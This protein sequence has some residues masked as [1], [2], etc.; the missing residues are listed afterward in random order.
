VTARPENGPHGVLVG[1]GGASGLLAA[2]AARWGGASVVLLEKNPRVGKKLLTTGNHQCNLS[3]LHLSADRFHGDP[4]LAMAVIGKFDLDA[5]L[6]FFGR[7]GLQSARDGQGRVYP[8]SY[9][10]ASVLDALRLEAEES[11]V[12][13]VAGTDVAEIERQGKGLAVTAKGGTRFIARRVILCTGGKAAPHTGSVGGGL[14]LARRLGHAVVEPFPAL[15]PLKLEGAHPRAMQG[16]RWEVVARL[17]VDGREGGTARGEAL[18]A[19]YGLSGPAALALSRNAVEAWSAGRRVEVALDLLPEQ[20]ETETLHCIRSRCLNKPDRSME[21]FLAGW[22]NKRIGQ[23]LLK[24]LGFDWSRPWG[25]LTGEEQ[26]RLA[27]ALHAWTF[28]VAGHTGWPNAQVTAGGVETAEVD[29][30][31]L[32]SRLVP[33]LHFAGEILNVDGD[34]GGYNLQWAWSSGWV[35]GSAAARAPEPSL[36]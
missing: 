29:P 10:A 36:P 5:T 30:E 7:L 19:A 17:L 35:A 9:Q 1:G 21:H 13:T 33:G 25:S 6:A 18:F 14:D 11:G 28:P 16:M 20:P 26:A 8:R 2:I 23:V 32:E 27:R 31:T 24:A 12:E 3:N 4:A 22:I 15:V 34:S